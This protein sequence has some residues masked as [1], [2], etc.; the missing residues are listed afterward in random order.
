MRIAKLILGLTYRCQCRCLHCSAGRYPVSKRDELTT[1]EVR[2]VIRAAA[3]LGTRTLNMFGGE[4]T[5][6]DDLFDLI[7]LAAGLVPE[8]TAD[9]NGQNITPDVAERLKAAGLSL[10]YIS[11]DGATAERHDA[12]QRR[13][14][15][16]DAVMRAMDACRGAGLRFEVSTCAIKGYIQSGELAGIVARARAMGAAGVRI[17]LP[18][19][20]GNWLEG[21]DVL[22]DAE[23]T[24]A[25]R[26]LAQAS[27][28]VS[29]VEEETGTFTHCNAFS[30]AS[31]YVSPYGD[32]Q[33]CNFIPIAFG[34]VRHEPLEL[35]VGRMS[36]DP[37]YLSDM[38]RGNCPMRR[39]EFV[40]ALRGE[41]DPAANLVRVPGP[42]PLRL[43]Q[44]CV[45]HC[46]FCA[47][48]AAVRPLAELLAELERRPDGTVDVALT[49]GEPAEHPDIE[50]LLRECR[51]LGLRPFL[52]TTGRPFAADP[53]RA[54]ALVKAGLD[55][56][57]I[58]L[59]R[60]D[61]AG[62]D[63]ITGVAGTL[64][65]QEAGIANLVQAG[66][67]VRVTLYDT[68]RDRVQAALHALR[69]L[70]VQM[71]L[72]GRVLPPDA[73]A[74][75][76]ACFSAGPGIARR[77]L[78]MRRWVVGGAIPT[79]GPDVL[80]VFP[81]CE[82]VDPVLQLPMSLLMLA[83]PL[84]ARGHRVKIVDQ[85]VT[86]R[87]KDE[88]AEAVLAGVACVGI[89]CFISRQVANA[90]AVARFVR[91]LQGDVPIV[92]GGMHP[93]LLPEQTLASPLVDAVVRGEGEE[94]LR[95]Y[96]E[97]VRAG[98]DPADVLGLSFKRLNGTCQHNPD[99][100]N[101][102]LDA[103]PPIPYELV[104]VAAYQRRGLLWAL[105]TSRGCPHR[106]G[107]C[108]VSK[109]HSRRWR[110]QSAERVLA[111][112]RRLHGFGARQIN[113]CEDNFFVDR[114]RGERLAQLLGESGLGIEWTASARV[115]DILRLSPE[116]LALYHRSGLRHLHIG[117]E[118]GSDRVLALLNKRIG[119]NDILA[120][121]LHLKAAG[122]VPEYI[123][124]M[125][126]PT[127]TEAE[128]QETLDLIA[129]LK[130]ENP[131]AW[132][133]RLNR[134]VPYPGTP[135]YDMALA[136]GFT[137]PERLEDWA[138]LGWNS[139]EYAHLVDYQVGF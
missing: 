48:P 66:V 88:V 96:F 42:L 64:A 36:A 12:F 1:D 43:G 55:T 126:F 125:G 124:V 94:T 26:A 77:V 18:M 86:P 41:L 35:I 74:G 71:V 56:A 28:F 136:A 39:P 99:R 44:A 33:P 115:D 109:V 100:P 3:H 119:R 121:N 51:R 128:R 138:E 120:A 135:L 82:S 116:T 27:D 91:G 90:A 15:S 19:C 95:E 29:I 102:D 101:L 132:F 123:F 7:A 22:L 83:A 106:C 118:S 69:R 25:V 6:R 45:H 61:A 14:G 49:G 8:V 13:P 65:A 63:A 107:F 75:E 37:L 60:Y 23:E 5:L 34:N 21:N 89:S 130:R 137:P 111:E 20:S 117:A 46:R 47:P 114:R 93:S 57:E 84:V 78:W 134:Y 30:G 131:D 9:T 40:S 50:A 53:Q 73:P 113:I 133:W 38:H 104:D 81:D 17:A 85:R 129:Q 108:A 31:I 87:W 112:M 79:H 59:L 10:L 32:V 105:Y 62:L 127:E 110:G 4:A 54:A 24:A 103:L 122:I 97:C 11:L 70:G 58:A 68:D 72:H 52:H 139:A 16:Y 2:T 92:W 98:R 67:D 76:V 80:L